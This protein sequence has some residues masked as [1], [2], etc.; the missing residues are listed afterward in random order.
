L[1][2]GLGAFCNWLIQRYGIAGISKALDEF[3]DE[4]AD[5]FRLR[6]LT[7]LMAFVALGSLI[8]VIAF[9]P[10][11]ERQAVAAGMAWTGVLGS[12]VVKEPSRGNKDKG[13]NKETR[14]SP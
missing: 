6:T 13:R 2:A 1:F 5:D 7:K 9:G 11:T 14:R 8:G 3:I 4:L 10:N 12:L